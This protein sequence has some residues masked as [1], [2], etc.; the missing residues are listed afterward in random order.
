MT[1]VARGDADPF[2]SAQTTL[3]WLYQ[4]IVWH[5]F[6]KRVTLTR[7]HAGAARYYREDG[8]LP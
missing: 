2:R 7:V 4:W 3:R 1:P 6:L 5:D 8:W